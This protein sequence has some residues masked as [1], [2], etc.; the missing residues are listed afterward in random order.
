[1]KHITIVGHVLVDVTLPAKQQALKMRLGGIFHSARTLWALGKPYSLAYVAP[2]Y[3]DR[4]IEQYALQH[5][6]V[7]CQ[8]IGNVDGSPNV[9]LVQQ[10]KEEGPQGYEL[11]LRDELKVDFNDQLPSFLQS[12]ATTDALCFPNADEI[13]HI[14]SQL[15]KESEIKVHLDANCP[16]LDLDSIKYLGRPLETFAI[17]TSSDLFCQKWTNDWAE[18]QAHF[19]PEYC[20][21]LLLKEN[22]GGSRFGRG[23]VEEPIKIPSQVVS[24]K[25]SVGVG[26]SFDASF[27]ALSDDN[28]DQTALAYSASIAAEYAA[29]TYPD[30]FKEAVQGVVAIPPNEIKELRGVSLPWEKRN[31]INIYVAAPDFDYVNSFHIDHLAECL[32]YHNFVPR[33]P[34]RE[35]GQMGE[36]ASQ[37]RKARLKNADLRI[38][39]ECQM[40]VAVNLFNDPGTL[41]E[42]G[43]A[44]ERGMPVIVYDPHS[45]AENLMLTELPTLTSSS[46]DD[47]IT[48]VFECG[49]RI[50]Q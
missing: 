22:R 19:F 26:D 17:S 23:I 42:I 11:L 49:A 38:L 37:D 39:D 12:Q 41:I 35:N 15:A 25:H 33:L 46:L 6:A 48:K 30:D 28:D 9:I 43:I 44:C 1:M 47:V 13:Q 18:F 10:A 4:A 16:R 31:G 20:N 29:T 7:A 27:I 40:L 24:I 21:A 2:T 34:V 5:G 50:T 14:F 32:R 3:L 8:K 36:G 45:R